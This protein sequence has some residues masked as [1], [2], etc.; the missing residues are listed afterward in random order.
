MNKYVRGVICGANGFLK[1]S[2][3]KIQ[4]MHH[5]NVSIPCF[6]SPFSEITMERK[7]QLKVG[8]KYRM[9][10]GSKLRIRN[11]AIITIGDDISINH[12]CIIV[13]R[14]KI[15][16]GN[17]V[18]FGP[19]VLIYDHDH[20]YKSPGGVSNGKYICEAIS[21]GENTWIGAG[22]IIL[23]GAHIGKNVT[24]AA[25]SVVRGVIPDNS[26]FYQK[27]ECNTIKY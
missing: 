14:E 11:N 7:A 5:L 16:I 21:I 2:L 4:H 8:K 9:R 3:L 15:E 19:N 27:R 18:Q 22:S 23:K 25:G 6:L 1:V 13:C 24:V 26:L 10:G 20:D 12:G 17:K